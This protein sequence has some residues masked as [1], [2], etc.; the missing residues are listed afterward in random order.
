MTATAPAGTRP[1]IPR[2]WLSPRTAVRSF[3]LLRAAAP[4]LLGY[5][6]VRVLGVLML[7]GVGS[8]RHRPVLHRLGTL[9]DAGWYV[10]IVEHGYGSTNGLVGSHGIAYS[11]RAFLPLFPWLAE[12]V[13]AVLPVAPG[14]ALVLVASLSGIGAAWGA[15]AVAARCHGHRAGVVA[16]VLWGVLPLA[17]LENTAYS[18]AL[19]S[20][21]A[22]WTL[23][24]VLDR[25]WLTAG[26]LCLLAG[27]SRPSAMALTAAVAA[28]AAVELYR[29]LRGRGSVR[30][31]RPLT[32][33]VLAPLGWVG[34]ILYVGRVEHSW[35]AYFRIQRAWG[36]SF[37]GGAATVKWFEQVFLSHRA[38]TGIPLAYAVMALT[39]F[40]YL[41]LFAIAVLQRQP[42]V[43]LVFSAGLLAIDLGNGS[44]YPPLARFLM[45]AIPLLFPLAASLSRLRSRATLL[46]VLAAAALVSGL[47]GAF[48]VFYGG[49]PS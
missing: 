17:V 7:L 32:A 3:P 9:W 15:Y 24:A 18:E 8:S 16:A 43:L 10:R 33:A 6:A 26:L 4:A 34:Y 28:A 22:V 13:R 36:S 21:L 31:W 35:G 46:V 27:L 40:A 41:L 12:A 14:T 19:F 42:L 47:Y 38:A 23:Y 2:Q 39:V 20:C 44:P 45:P 29:C 11:T 37:D 30:W 49:A 25:R 48:V 1:Q 5:C